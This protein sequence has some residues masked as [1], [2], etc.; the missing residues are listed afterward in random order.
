M[1]VNTVFSSTT[2]AS[3]EAL[4]AEIAPAM[5]V[6]L[7]EDGMAKGAAWA[8]VLMLLYG[9]FSKTDWGGFELY[10][11]PLYQWLLLPFLLAALSLPHFIKRRG[12]LVEVRYRRQNGKW[13]W[14][15]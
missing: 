8:V 4:I 15:R 12:V 10:A 2:T 11:T 9:G 6:K 13:R 14:E 1:A 5:L 3:D 7:R